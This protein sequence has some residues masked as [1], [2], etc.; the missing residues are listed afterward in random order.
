MARFVDTSAYDD[1]TD[2]F[3]NA[4]TDAD[5]FLAEEAGAILPMTKPSDDSYTLTR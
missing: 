3:G 5:G 4:A 1:R 2:S